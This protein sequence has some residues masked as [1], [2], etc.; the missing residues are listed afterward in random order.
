MRFNVKNVE[1]TFVKFVEVINDREMWS[2][3]ELVSETGTHC[4]VISHGWR[5]KIPVHECKLISQTEYNQLRL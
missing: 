1:T 5:L 3:G 4:D 2:V